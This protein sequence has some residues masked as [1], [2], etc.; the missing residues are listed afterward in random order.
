MLKYQL[1]VYARLVVCLGDNAVRTAESQL[2]LHKPGS[3]G[4]V[5]GGTN[6]M[7]ATLSHKSTANQSLGRGAEKKG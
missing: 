1:S 7:L 6:T 5:A 4:A 2:G 3:G